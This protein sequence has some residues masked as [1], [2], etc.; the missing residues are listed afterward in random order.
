MN[1]KKNHDHDEHTSATSETRT[2]PDTQQP[3]PAAT[4]TPTTRPSAPSSAEIELAALKDKQLRLMADFDNFRKRQTRER[5]ETVR[6]ATETLLQELL[7]VL[8]HLELALSN[9]PNKADPL[10]AG[11]QMIA[12][13]FRSALQRFDLKPFHAVGEPFDPN[14][15]EAVSEL[16]S[17]DVPAHHVL[18][19]LRR[20]YMLGGRLLR[21]AQVVISSGPASA[22]ASAEPV[23]D[24]AASDPATTSS[25]T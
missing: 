10:A 22:S 9:A 17:A 14:R 18:H 2:A 23:C 19:Q 20:G 8:D 15:H 21:P 1:R 12:D 11:V 5:D 24:A 7:P 13:Q 4:E 16:A 6:R 3:A 25:A